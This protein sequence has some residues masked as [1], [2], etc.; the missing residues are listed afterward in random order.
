MTLLLDTVNFSPTNT[1]S[2]HIPQ[3]EMKTGEIQGNR[4]KTDNQTLYPEEALYMIER[5]QLELKQEDIPIPL[6]QAKK[7]LKVNQDVYQVYCHL[8]QKG[9]QVKRAS[10]DPMLYDSDILKQIPLIHYN[11]F[12][13]EAFSLVILSSEFTDFNTISPLANLLCFVSGNNLQFLRIK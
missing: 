12:K 1:H 5:N 9:Y 2:Q 3:L 10:L 8:K 4:V 11:V 13:T 6:Q 7:R